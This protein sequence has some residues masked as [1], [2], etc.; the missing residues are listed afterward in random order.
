MFPHTLA[1]KKILRPYLSGNI[2]L[3]NRLIRRYAVTDAAVHDSKMLGAVLDD[4]NSGDQIW[5]DSA[6]RRAAIEAVLELLQFDSQ[7]HERGY[8]NHP[9]SEKQKDVNREKSKTRAKVEH[10]FGDWVMTMGANYCVVLANL[11]PQPSLG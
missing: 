5:A 4:D 6:D 10:V 7:I 3:E 8:R 9:L 11:V 1:T 2:F